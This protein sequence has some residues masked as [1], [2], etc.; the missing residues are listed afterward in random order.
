MAKNYFGQD[1]PEPNATDMFGRPVYMFDKD[2]SRIVSTGAAPDP[3]TAI[4]SLVGVRPY[5]ANIGSLRGVANMASNA[6]SA[7]DSHQQHMAN[8]GPMSQPPPNELNA[9]PEPDAG[10][11]V[12]DL[13]SRRNAARGSA[14]PMHAG[15]MQ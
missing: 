4:H 14:A 12:R 10:N 11:R 13:L 3:E 8:N 1:I 9:N 6:L 7:Y 15:A 5:G 2:P